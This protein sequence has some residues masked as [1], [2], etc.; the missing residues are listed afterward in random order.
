MSRFRHQLRAGA[1]ALA[2]GAAVAVASPPAAAAASCPTEAQIK[3]QVAALVAQLKADVPSG[4]ARAAVAK[5]LLE[6]RR[7]L[8]GEKARTPAQRAAFGQ[9]ISALARQ[10]GDAET[11]VAR[12]AILTQIHALQEQKERGGL[13][14]AE[15]T[16]LKADNAALRAAVVAKLDTA[17][18]VRTITAKF[19]GIHL[20][21]TC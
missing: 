1:A 2:V 14:A 13:T 19:R 17:A 20:S 11:E 5:A 16:Q 21:F 4:T 3:A 10:L 18:E 15:R 8:R 12:R 7:A 6:S 9:A